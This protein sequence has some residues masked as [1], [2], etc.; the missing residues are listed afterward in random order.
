MCQAARDWWLTSRILI[1]I[2]LLL[3]PV[4]EAAQCQK[5]R[6]NLQPLRYDEDWSLL[7]DPD[8]KEEA[9]DDIKYIPLGRDHW[10]LSFGGEIRY[11]YENYESP[12]FGVGPETPSGY[13]L[14]RYLLHTDWHFG[15]HFRL[16]AQFQS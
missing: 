5:K 12:G 7:S 16:F 10:Y 6:P 14:Q 3:V 8:C 4:T 1:V 2:P 9:I 13:I 15:R 11:R